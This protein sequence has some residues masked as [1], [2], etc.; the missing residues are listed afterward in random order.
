MITWCDI[1]EGMIREQ[2]KEMKGYGLDG[3]DGG[4]GNTLRDALVMPMRL[5]VHIHYQHLPTIVMHI[6]FSA[7]LYMSNVLVCFMK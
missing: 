4:K 7:D 5:S 6:K 1:V 3:V 2:I